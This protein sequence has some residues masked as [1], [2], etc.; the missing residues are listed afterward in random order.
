MIKRSEATEALVR[1]LDDDALVVASLGFTKYT[2][3]QTKDRP[4]NFYMWNSMGMASSMGLGM[5][6]AQPDKRVVIL[7][8]DGDLLMNLGSLTTEANR[9]PR[10]VV[11]VV[12]DNRMYHI[13]G[14]QPTATAGRADLARIAEGAGFEKVA[15]V[16]TLEAFEQVIDRAL[17]EEGPW[18]IHALIEPEVPPKIRP[19]RSPTFIKHRFMSDL[20]VQH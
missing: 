8:G 17:K 4:R 20:G 12:W 10:N 6:M 13:T 11:H 2:L 15:Q 5:A 7:Q 16:E 19:H 3:F 18:F 14:A 9:N 1:R